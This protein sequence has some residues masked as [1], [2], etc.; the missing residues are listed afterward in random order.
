M[1]LVI[2]DCARW[3]SA[4]AISRLS[5]GYIGAHYGRLERFNMNAHAGEWD[6]ETPCPARVRAAIR[7]TRADAQASASR[8]E[9]RRRPGPIG[10]VAFTLVALFRSRVTRCAALLPHERRR[11]AILAPSRYPSF[12]AIS[13]LSS[14]GLPW[15]RVAFMHWPTKNPSRPVLP[16]RYCSTLSG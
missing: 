6:R 14:F 1:H 13:W 7:A 12:F 3:L 16:P 5:T 8:P 9:R 15:P 10:P 2:R 11:S 4:D